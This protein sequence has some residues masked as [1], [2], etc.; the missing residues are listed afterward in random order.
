MPNDFE[1]IVKDC[2]S[3][4]FIGGRELHGIS[5][6]TIRCENASGLVTMECT[7]RLS[8]LPKLLADEIGKDGSGEAAL[9][10]EETGALLQNHRLIGFDPDDPAIE[11]TADVT[12]GRNRIEALSVRIR[13]G[14]AE[15]EIRLI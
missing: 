11:Y 14:Q 12:L 8:P 13:K 7:M 6:Y 5:S 15:K 9:R 4:L 3:R 2:T 1:L 10:Y